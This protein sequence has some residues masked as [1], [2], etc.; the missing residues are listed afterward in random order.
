MDE[1]GYHNRALDA[2]EEL[3]SLRQQVAAITV[4][5]REMDI[6]Y[7]LE[8]NRNN[9]LIKNLAAVQLENERL[10]AK[11]AALTA[12]R[13]DLRIKHQVACDTVAR[14]R[15][16]NET[17]SGYLS[18]TKASFERNL[19]A[20]QVQAP[21]TPDVK[22]MVDRFLRWKLPKGFSPDCG[23]SFDGRKDDEWNKNKT[24][25]IG[26]NLFDADQA[27]QMIEYMLRPTVDAAGGLGK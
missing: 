24:W 25:P 2:M 20:A 17:I 22:A 15:E 18:T 9:D 13:D 27:R 26:T 1:S 14:Q 23:I 6:L 10:Q 19:L 16:D 5:N 21:E 3:E 7:G 12:E 8:F 4:E 11:V